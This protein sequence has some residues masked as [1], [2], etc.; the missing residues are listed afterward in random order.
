MSGTK[1]FVG[2]TWN[3]V[4]IGVYF[5]KIFQTRFEFHDLS[6]TQ[7]ASNEY[8]HEDMKII[9][10]YSVR[11]FSLPRFMGCRWTSSLA[12]STMACI[13]LAWRWTKHCPKVKTFTTERQSLG[14]C[15]I[16]T[17]MVRVTLLA[18]HLLRVFISL[19]RNSPTRAGAASFLIFLDHTQWHAPLSV[20]FHW[21]R[22]QSVAK[23]F[24]WHH[25]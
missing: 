18:T 11:V 1:P 14:G 24:T 23:T 16:A 5:Y 10:L 7:E 20:G 2:I 8:K 3:L 6:L 15:G 22:Y 17:F 19:W 25:K 4:I 13:S 9:K 21:T 12:P